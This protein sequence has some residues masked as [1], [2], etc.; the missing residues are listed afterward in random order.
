MRLLL[1]FRLCVLSLFVAPIIGC[2][3]RQ[4]LLYEWGNYPRHQYDALLRTNVTVEEQIQALES[5]AQKARGAN[6]VLPPGF[7]AHLG[8]LHL[9]T[10]NADRA[11][12]LWAAEKIAFPESTLFMDQLLKRL[13]GATMATDEEKPK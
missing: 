1:I 6:R 10:G 13:S 7:R 5:H 2:V 12:E 9:N 8:M 11:R 4:P 3:A